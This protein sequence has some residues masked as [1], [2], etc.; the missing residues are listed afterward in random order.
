M[1]TKSAEAQLKEHLS[2]AI[3]R[4]LPSSNLRTE[5]EDAHTLA[6]AVARDVFRDVALWLEE[7]PQSSNF[8]FSESVEPRE[9]ERL[10]TL[11]RLRTLAQLAHSPYEGAYNGELPA[12]PWSDPEPPPQPSSPE[13][14]EMNPIA[15]LLRGAS[16][17]NSGQMPWRITTRD[18]S[19][20]TSKLLAKLHK[21]QR[22]AVVTYRGVP[23]FLVV[24]V[25]Q[26]DLVTLFLGNAPQLREDHEAARAEL[27]EDEG[28]FYP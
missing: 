27:T 16:E 8:A 21:D 15:Q 7:V 11:G 14:T 1:T 22:T 6:S 9:L 17:K 20:H 3:E 28:T 4:R 23:A 10:R 2:E 13:R 25:N 12:Q 18:L 24:P 26:D 19:R 5:P